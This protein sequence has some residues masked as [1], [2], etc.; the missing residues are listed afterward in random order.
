MKRNG[1]QTCIFIFLQSGHQSG[2]AVNYEHISELRDKEGRFVLITG[3][4]EG[5]FVS[6]LNVYAPPGSDW[7]FYRQ[8]FEIMTTKSQG[9]VICGGDFNVHLNPRLDSSS[10]NSDSKGISKKLVSLMKEMGIIDV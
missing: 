6:L 2:H 10:G 1:L 7:S 9:I 4:M 3:R 8:I 5:T